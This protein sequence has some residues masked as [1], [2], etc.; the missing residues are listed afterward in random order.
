MKNGIEK[1]KGSVG[2]FDWKKLLAIIPIGV[3]LVVVKQM[4]DFVSAI[5]DGI[6]SVNKVIDGL[7]DVEKKLFQ[8]FLTPK[9]SRPRL[10]HLRR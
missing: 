6:G 10:R 4:Y 1:L 8:N 2:N 5:S 9:H 3:V 7:A